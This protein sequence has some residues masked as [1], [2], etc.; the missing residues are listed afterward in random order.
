M[1]EHADHLTIFPQVRPCDM[2]PTWRQKQTDDLKSWGLDG[3]SS[4][5]SHFSHIPVK[6]SKSIPVVDIPS[7]LFVHPSN[8][9]DSFSGHDEMRP[10]GEVASKIPSNIQLW[11]HSTCNCPCYHWTAA[12]GFPEL[13][14]GLDS[15]TSRASH[16][17]RQI[18]FSNPEETDFTCCHRRYQV[19]DG[20][21]L[22]D[23]SH[24]R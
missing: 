21:G 7:A 4:L 17:S 10:V 24:M 11:L 5:C 18:I 3:L 9:H 14:S 1:S 20:T 16:F 12:D 23:L 2:A 19:Q 13:C 6:T 15:S 8:L 22:N